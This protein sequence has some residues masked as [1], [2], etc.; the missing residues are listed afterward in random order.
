VPWVP[1]AHGNKGRTRNF[2]SKESKGAQASCGLIYSLRKEADAVRGTIKHSGE[3]TEMFDAAGRVHTDCILALIRK[4]ED[5]RGSSSRVAYIAGKKLGSAPTRNRA[6]RRMREAAMIYDAPWHG[7]D[8]VFV[9]KSK[10]INAEHGA[11]IRNMEQIKR[12]LG[13][14][15]ARGAGR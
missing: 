3:I 15:G 13:E 6:K 12:E 1:F 10:I 11:V 7:Y 4:K 2:I 8:V 14:D 5:G 9:A